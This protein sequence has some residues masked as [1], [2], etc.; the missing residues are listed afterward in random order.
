[1][2]RFGCGKDM[3]IDILTRHGYKERKTFCGSTAYDGGVN[4]CEE[5]EKKHNVPLPY[6]DESDMDW[7]ERVSNN[8]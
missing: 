8:Y 3:V 4:Q 6:E 7:Y 5:C 2:P 1:M